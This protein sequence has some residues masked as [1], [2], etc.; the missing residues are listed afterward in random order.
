MSVAFPC[1]SFCA[2][3]VQLLLQSLL[4]AAVMSVFSLW[5]VNHDVICLTVS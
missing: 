3:V 4:L 1:V 2:D 5:T